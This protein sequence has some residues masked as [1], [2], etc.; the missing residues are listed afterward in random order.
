MAGGSGM[1]MSHKCSAF[2][3]LTIASLL[4][5]PLIAQDDDREKANEKVAEQTMRDFA[6][7]VVSNKKRE[8]KALEFLRQPDGDP[9][10]LALGKEIAVGGCAPP[11]SQMRFQ[12]DLFSRSVYTAL[13]RKYYGKLAPDNAVVTM[14]TDYSVEYAVSSTPVPQSQ[15]ALRAFGDCTVASDAAAAH[16]FAISEMRGSDEKTAL[17]GVMPSLEKCLQEGTKLKFSRT[18]LKGIIAE[19]LYK[20]RQR[21]ASAA[22]DERK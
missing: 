11:G 1:N 18:V 7:C 6:R 17:P 14:P 2:L 21:S 15:L 10:Q 20:I 5:A 4:S 22:G 12:P 16:R 19:S 13:Y 3:A 9:K 8:A